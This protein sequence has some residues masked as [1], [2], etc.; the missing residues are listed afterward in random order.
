MRFMRINSKY[1]ICPSKFDSFWRSTWTPFSRME[2]ASPWTREERSRLLGAQFGWT[3][4]ERCTYWYNPIPRRTSF[5]SRSKKVYTLSCK[6]PVETEKLTCCT[7]A[8]ALK[9]AG[10]IT[11]LKC[12]FATHIKKPNSRRP[13][14]RIIAGSRLQRRGNREI[15]CKDDAS[16]DIED[17]SSI[18]IRPELDSSSFQKSVSFSLFWLKHF[19]VGSHSELP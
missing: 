15:N 9:F 16:S 17:F 11:S 19:S 5:R 4:E 7:G 10:E 18:V 1:F 3:L 12:P 14:S 13:S 8:T 2:T 6:H